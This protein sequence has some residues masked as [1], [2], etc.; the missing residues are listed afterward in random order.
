VADRLPPGRALLG[1][2]LCEAGVA[3]FALLSKPFLYDL[4]AVELAGWWTRPRRCS[5]SASPGLA[6]PTT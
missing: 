2:A 6:L 3:A 1:F 4:M 5:R